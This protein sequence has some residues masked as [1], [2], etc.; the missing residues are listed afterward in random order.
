MRKVVFEGEE[1]ITKTIEIVP[2]DC[3]WM[4][5]ILLQKERENVKDGSDNNE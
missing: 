4:K 3:I 2:R 5:K 1:I